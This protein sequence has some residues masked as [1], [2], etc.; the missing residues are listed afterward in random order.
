MNGVVV[1]LRIALRSL[2]RSPA[3]S[4]VAV[5]TLALGIGANSTLFS[6]VNGVLLRPLPYPD[7]D[8]IVRVH[9]VGDEGGLSNFSEPNFRDLKE[10]SRGFAGLSLVTAAASSISGGNEPVRAVTARVSADFLRVMGV[11]PVFGRGFLPEEQV[12]GAQLSAL[13]GHGFWERNLGGERDL[14]RVLLHSGEIPIR[15][16]GVMPPEFDF[17]I[18]A[19]LWLP[20]E[21]FPMNIERTAHNW[22]VMG[23][24][25]EGTSLEAAGSEASTLARRL[26]EEYGDATWMSDMRLTPLGEQM[27]G[28]VRSALLILLGA[29]GVLFL[30]ACAN[31]TNLLL[32][33]AEE[34]RQELAIRLAL[35][36]R[37]GRVIRHFVAET[38]VLATTSGVLGVIL[39]LA[40]VTFLVR[41]QPGNLP[42]VEEIGVDRWVLLFSLV[43]SLGAA[44][45]L[46]VAVAWRALKE[47]NVDLAGGRSHAGSRRGSRVRGGLVVS[48]VGLSL[49]LLVGA[50]L[51]GRSFLN[52]TAVDLGF[53]TD[54]VLAMTVALPPMGDG[55][56]TRLRNF[57]GEVIGGLAALPGVEAAGGI[58][59]LPLGTSGSNGTFFKLNFPDE[60]SSMEEL[61]ALAADPSRLGQGE[62]RV[63]TSGYFRALSIPLLEGRLFEGSDGPDAP[64]VAVVS[65]SFAEVAWPDESPLGKFIQYG[66]MDGDLRP[67]TVVGVVG[68]VREAG[69]ESESRPTFYALS[70]QRPRSSSAFT[71]VLS[72]AGEASSLAGPAR[73]V[74]AGADP[75]IPGNIRTMDQLFSA[76]LAERR[77]NLLLLGIFGGTAL[78]LCLMGIYGVMAFGVAQR[79]REIGVRVALGAIP[80]SVIRMV[81]AQAVTLTAIGIALGLAGAMA[82]TG[83][84]EGF[85]YGVERFDPITFIAVPLVLMGAAVLAA[86]LP[87]RRANAVDPI[88]ALRSE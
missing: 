38:V 45:T 87:A 52:A 53:E 35:G 60:A 75:G 19:E 3:F 28:R 85:L 44:L 21:A 7:A 63:A 27:V 70:D 84:V 16:V 5:L 26:K 49:V 31:V 58:N 54:G 72:A 20:A 46:G 13:V 62:F 34:R 33:R 41:A 69:V 76:N 81:V 47:G 15:V 40:G 80:E 30:I 25:A 42:R 88:T 55:D 73:T 14:S 37:V 12:E 78:L 24:V 10:Q 82:L 51:L 43:L 2:L 77:F 6:V 18:G 83:F 22:Q 39:A 56:G 4:L 71:Y 11:A 29:A 36:A 64:H 67:F 68:D 57:H 50:G 59:A 32:A 23:R 1:D 48:Q 61:R 74:L 8:R 17:P 65:R 86:W 79:T 66:N 9:Q